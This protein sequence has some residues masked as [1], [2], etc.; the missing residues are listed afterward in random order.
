MITEVEERETII[1][2][3]NLKEKLLWVLKQNPVNEEQ[4]NHIIKGKEELTKL[5]MW[6]GLLGVKFP[7]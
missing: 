6:L 1:K 4:K 2:L 3:L 5:N 7:N